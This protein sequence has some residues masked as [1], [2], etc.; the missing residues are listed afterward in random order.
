MTNLE[1]N[2]NP[3]LSTGSKKKDKKAVIIMSDPTITY[4]DG[5]FA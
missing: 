1:K 5:Y 2:S 4:F 3:M